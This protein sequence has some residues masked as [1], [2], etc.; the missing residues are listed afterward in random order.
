M[1]WNR[2]HSSAMTAHHRES[3]MRRYCSCCTVRHVRAFVSGLLFTTGIS[4]T[5]LSGEVPLGTL[6]APMSFVAA[7]T[8]GNCSECSWIAAIG[9]IT[10]DT[11]AALERLW[12]PPD[13]GWSPTLAI[14]SRGGDLA[15]ALELGRVLRR[16]KAFV[17]V[18]ETTNIRLDPWTVQEQGPGICASACVYAFL[19]GATRAVHP[20]SLIGLHQFRSATPEA[21]KVVAAAL[22]LAGFS[23]DQLL[24]GLVAEYVAEMGIDG[25]ILSRAVQAPAHDV[26]LLSESDLAALGI[27]TSREF[28]LWQIEP[29]RGGLIA[30][31]K[32]GDAT[33]SS[34]QVTAFCTAGGPPTLMLTFVIPSFKSR[35]KSAQDVPIKGLEIYLGGSDVDLP[36]S[37][38]KY[39]IE[40]SGQVFLQG[41]L[42]ARAVHTLL[43]A[44]EIRVSPDLPYYVVRNAIAVVKIDERARQSLRLAFKNCY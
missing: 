31:S 2:G 4:G 14:H 11:P 3:W 41:S 40:E 42:D 35:F 26:E 39:R 43:Q 34:R 37:Q 9:T 25:R 18:A 38:V 27:V 33:S 17:V 36:V 1:M 23:L 13:D 20:G 5:V 22:E 12:G 6:D 28:G 30:F 15:A 10:A 21:T 8:G 16:Y 32:T 44:K 29:Y 19:G 7:G 24:M